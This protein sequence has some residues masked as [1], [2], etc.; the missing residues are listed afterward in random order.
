[1]RLRFPRTA[2]QLK[3]PTLPARLPIWQGHGTI[4]AVI[5]VSYGRKL[6]D[7]LRSPELALSGGDEIEY[8]E[9]EGLEH[10]A[11]PEELDDLTV[12][13]RRVLPEATEAPPCPRA[14][15]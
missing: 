1:M 7:F 6:R 9:Y 2:L 4:D 11:S 10:S 14:T 5:D 15:L 3:S 8:K 13:L 12:W